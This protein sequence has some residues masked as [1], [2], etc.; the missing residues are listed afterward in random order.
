MRQTE[1]GDQAAKERVID[2][3]RDRRGGVQQGMPHPEACPGGNREED[4]RFETV[5]D[6]KQ[7]DGHGTAH[8]R[9]QFS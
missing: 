8:L 7:C 4:A 3:C 2:D 6:K 5:N 9:E 1:S